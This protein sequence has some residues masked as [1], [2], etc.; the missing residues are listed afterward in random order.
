VTQQRVSLHG[1]AASNAYCATCANRGSSSSNQHQKSPHPRKFR[2]ST[3]YSGRERCMACMAG[4]HC[5]QAACRP[6]HSAG[7][8]WR[9]GMW[10]R[11]SR[12]TP[13]SVHLHVQEHPKTHTTPSSQDSIRPTTT[14]EVQRQG[15][16]QPLHLL[17]DL[18]NQRPMS[19]ATAAEAHPRKSPHAAATLGA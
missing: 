14:T 12:T 10:C 16:E 13:Q 19:T 2:S 11:C 4:L 15:R 6:A 1:T 18:S 5:L 7:Q 9:M 3:Q 8:T 17:L